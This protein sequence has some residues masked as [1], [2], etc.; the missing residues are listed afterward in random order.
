VAGDVVPYKGRTKHSGQD[1]TTRVALGEK[2]LDRRNRG[3]SF[4]TISQDLGV[5]VDSCKRYQNLALESRVAPTVDLFRRQQTDRLDLTQRELDKQMEIANAL[6]Q[7]AYELRY[8]DDGR[9]LSPN[10]TLIGQAAALRNQTIALQLR[11]DERRAKL[12]GLDAPVQAEVR[13][14]HV[15]PVDAEMAE[16]VREAKM[17]A[18]GQEMMTE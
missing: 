11:L 1:Y 14:T 16:M 4:W 18:A 12:N 5:S 8:D 17:R 2:V 6:G 9:V 7:S 15:D 13:V 3:E 10:V